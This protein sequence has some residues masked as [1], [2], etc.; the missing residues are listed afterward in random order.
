MDEIDLVARRAWST[1][2]PMSVDFMW[3]LWGGPYSPMFGKTIKT[4]ERTY[5]RDES[6]WKEPRNHYYTFH[7]ERRTAKMILHEFGLY[8]DRSHII[9]GHTP[10]NV[11]KGE[12]PILADGLLYIIDGGFCKAYQKTTGIAG[13]TL[14]FNSHGLR[15]KTHQPFTSLKQALNENL[16]IHSDTEIVEVEEKRVMV[17][18]TDDGVTVREKIED[19]KQLLEAYRR[20]LLRE[21]E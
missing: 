2:D 1:L 18:D 4:F 19:L 8:S 14:I 3:Y 11:R 21:R 13:Y 10:V 17:A 9:N 12:S 7:E 20:G 15:L 5:I 16:D 6:T